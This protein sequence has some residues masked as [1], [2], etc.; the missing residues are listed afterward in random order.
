MK[1]TTCRIKDKVC[2]LY[3]IGDIHV[4]DKNFHGE[5]EAK[6]K[7]YIDHI[8]RTKNARVF[9]M[10]DIINVATRTSKSNP[11]D[12]TMNLQE[13]IRYAT[14]LLM[15]VKDK[16]IGAITGNHEARLE[17]SVGYNPTTAICANLGIPYFGISAVVAF[18]VGVGRQPTVYHGYFHHTTGGG[19]TVGAAI[20]RVDK[21]RQI[22]VNADFYVGGHNHRL[23]VFDTQT[24]EIDTNHGKIRRLRQVLVDAGSYLSWNGSYAESKQYPPS[25][26]GSPRIRLSSEKQGVKDVHVSL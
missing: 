5:G 6:L 21:L 11:F 15:P 9:L 13:Q 4:G 16:I 20:N 19:S 7:A 12:Q 22:V 2:Y 8:A 1:Y 25:K 10:G 14:E 26:L 18:K 23:G 24:Y 17:D 3:P